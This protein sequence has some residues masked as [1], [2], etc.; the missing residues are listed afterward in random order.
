MELTLSAEDRSFRDELREFLAREL[1]TDGDRRGVDYFEIQA[2]EFERLRAWHRK[3]F[4]HRFVGIT[5]PRRYGGR[6]APPH[7]QAILLDE[8]VRAGAPPTINV[9]GITLC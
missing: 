1:A 2:R 4:D 6:E 3:L 5:W 8:L 7:Q 9:L